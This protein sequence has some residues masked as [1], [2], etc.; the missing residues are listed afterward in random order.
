MN[1][2]VI[3][4]AFND[5]KITDIDNYN[6]PYMDTNKIISI[7]ECHTLYDAKLTAMQW[8]HLTDDQ[9]IFGTV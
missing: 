9:I 5:Y 4:K 1:K 7:K 3:Y 2:Y 8:L 6:A